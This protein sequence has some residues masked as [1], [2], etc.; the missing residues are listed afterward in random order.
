V[1][2]S[3]FHRAV[4]EEFGGVHGPVLVRELWLTACASTA[5]EALRSGI[6]PREVWNALCDEMNVPSTQRHGRGLKN[7]VEQA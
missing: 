5:E 1:R 7:P 4:R 3:E 6:A 2:L